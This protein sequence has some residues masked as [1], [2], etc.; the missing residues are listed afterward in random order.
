MGTGLAPV[1]DMSRQ[2]S[3]HFLD[4]RDELLFPVN[5]TEAY[6]DGVLSSRSPSASERERAEHMSGRMP[7]GQLKGQV[8]RRARI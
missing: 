4:L 6:R 2:G 3:R 1:A 7:Q 5:S 8:L